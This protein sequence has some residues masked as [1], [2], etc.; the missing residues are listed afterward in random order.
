VNDAVDALHRA[1]DVRNVADVARCV[2]HARQCI[3]VISGTGATHHQL[4][5]SPAQWCGKPVQQTPRRDC[6][7]PVKQANRMAGQQQ[8]SHDHP[9][10]QPETTCHKNGHIFSVHSKDE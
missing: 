10:D 3:G 2:L 7:R 6:L 8:F 9:A 5:Q 4:S 1:S